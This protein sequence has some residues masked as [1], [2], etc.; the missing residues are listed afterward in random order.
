MDFDSIP[1]GVDFRELIKKTLEK[2]KVVIALIGPDWLGGS[3]SVRNGNG[4]NGTD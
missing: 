4:Q 1:Y 3:K 2:A